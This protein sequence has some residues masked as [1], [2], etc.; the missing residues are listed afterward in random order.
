ML[1]ID[2]SQGEAGGQIL[3]TA[4]ALSAATGTAC[5]V[6]DIRANRPKPGL[7]AQ[8]LAGVLALQRFCGAEVKGVEMGSR[9]VEFAPGKGTVSE[10]S[11]DI[12]TAGAVSLVLQALLPAVVHAQRRV[13]LELNG[14]TH[15]AFAPTTSYVSEVLRFWLERMGIALELMV[16]RVGF[17]PKGGGRV[18]CTIE[19]AKLKPLTAVERGAERGWWVES[20][21]SADLQKGLVAERQLRELPREVERAVRSESSVGTGS[22]VLAV[23]RYEHA[24]LGASALGAPGKKAERVGVE[25]FSELEAAVR[26]GAVVDK[27]MADQLLPFLALAKGRSE[28]AVAEV[29]QH[30]R[31]NI[32]IIEKFLPVKFAVDEQ[33]KR[34]AVEG[35]GLC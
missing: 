21:A 24:R 16:E 25:A 12:G 13:T 1:V 31:T 30:A 29:T 5:R 9:E 19:P 11:F 22:A 23:A 33:R 6:V 2:G 4:L 14:G 20:I 35:A 7:M 32:A 8:H 26:S 27:H 3:R 28:L 10:L 34:I 17:Y 18:R 15:V